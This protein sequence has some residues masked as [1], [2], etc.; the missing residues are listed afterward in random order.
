VAVRGYRPTDA[1]RS[2]LGLASVVPHPDSEQVL[3]LI[4]QR[5]V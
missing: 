3:D 4:V 5:I 1:S 2:A